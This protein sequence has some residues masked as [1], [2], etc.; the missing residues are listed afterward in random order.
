MKISFHLLF[1]KSRDLDL[2]IL[3]RERS[4]RDVKMM[5]HQHEAVR[6]TQTSI[7]LFLESHEIAKGQ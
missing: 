4:A 6:S 5:V 3:G 2:P 7:T 1:D